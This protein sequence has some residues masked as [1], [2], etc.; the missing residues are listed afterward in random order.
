MIDEVQSFQLI[1]ELIDWALGHFGE[2]LAVFHEELEECVRSSERAALLT[3]RVWDDRFAAI[4]RDEEIEPTGSKRGPD[5]A[6]PA[7]DAHLRLDTNGALRCVSR[8]VDCFI[9]RAG[10]DF[11]SLVNDLGSDFED[12]NRSDPGAWSEWQAYFAEEAAAGALGTTAVVSPL[13]AIEAMRRWLATLQ[14]EFN[15]DLRSL[16]DQ[17][18]SEI[19]APSNNDLRLHQAWAECLILPSSI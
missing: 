4:V 5:A 6:V 16:S 15:D 2:R 1:T 14:P 11:R 13:Q 3:W 18:A 10:N 19:L 8:Y 12:M 7:A 9:V 17:I